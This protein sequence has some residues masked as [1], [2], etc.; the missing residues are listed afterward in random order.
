[1]TL[2]ELGQALFVSAP[3]ESIAATFRAN[4][5]QGRIAA[6]FAARDGV[7][8]RVSVQEAGS[9]RVRF[10]NALY[11][12]AEA[13]LVNTAGGVAGGDR[14]ELAFDLGPQASLAVTTAAAEKIY[15]AAD[16]AAQA[17]T[18]LRLA[19][20]ARL[21]WLPQE[22]ILFDGARL[23][24]TIDIELAATASLVFAEAVVFGR[25][26]RGESVDAGLFHDRW[27]LR[28]DGAL[29]FAD[30]FRVE[31][32][33]RTLRHKATGDGAVAFASLLL[34]PGEDAH[35]AAIRD[36]EAAY[37]GDVGVSCWNGV[38]LA[39]FCARDGA[40]LRHDLMVVVAALGQ[41]LPRLWL[42]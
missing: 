5:S 37:A 29:V 3:V 38:A 10:P 40:T 15:R 34:A 31:G 30:A 18:T 27:R 20:G 21:V 22:A 35:V 13:V 28:R 26:A 24:R 1:M 39:R 42:N 17:V 19:D 4:R 25:T 14:Q 16:E 7:T 33:R 9:L 8:R 23:S 2:A 36:H 11:E 41:Q 6:A 12:A 32:G